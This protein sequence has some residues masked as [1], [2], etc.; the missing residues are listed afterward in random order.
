[1]APPHVA[2]SAGTDKVVFA[3]VVLLAVLAVV[4]YVQRL[5][6]SKGKF[7]NFGPPSNQFGSSASTHPYAAAPH[8]LSVSPGAKNVVMDVGAMSPL[9]RYGSALRCAGVTSGDEVTER[10]SSVPPVAYRN[11]PSRLPPI[12]DIQ[13]LEP[14]VGDGIGPA[15]DRSGDPLLVRDSMRSGAHSTG[16]PGHDSILFSSGDV[17]ERW[18]LPSI[19]PVEAYVRVPGLDMYPESP[20][21]VDYGAIA[22]KAGDYFD[23]ASQNA[24]PTHEAV[25]V[26]PTYRTL[27]EPDHEPG[28]GAT[29]W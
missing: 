16:D 26:P 5:R 4:L 10:T 17:P 1:M 27:R 20:Y 23:V 29:S 18:R 28:V 9:L 3:T 12:E 19:P 13:G 25:G 24:R 15:I 6:P 11:L 8:N 2:H 22:D 14:I 21:A 7:A